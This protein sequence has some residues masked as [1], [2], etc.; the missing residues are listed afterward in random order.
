MKT[1]I[2]VSIFLA[3]IFYLNKKSSNKHFFKSEKELKSDLDLCIKI[4][5]NFNFSIDYIHRFIEA[6]N[7]FTL[8][9]KDYNGTSIINDRYTISGLEVQSLIH[10]YDWIKA[11][12][13]KEL[14]ISNIHYANALRK[15]NVNWI[16]VWTL[17][18]GLEIVSIFKSIKYLK[19]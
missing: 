16:W 8:S 18:L 10:D 9:P 7:Y 4:L 6:Y 14:H 11:K 13:L 19:N 15:V 17:F 3:V 12:S 2:I 5:T 1:A